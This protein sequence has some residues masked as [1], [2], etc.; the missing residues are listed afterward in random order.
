MTTES[1][2]ILGIILEFFLGVYTVFKL[3]NIDFAHS[4]WTTKLVLT[5]TGILGL[6][7]I[8]LICLIDL[9]VRLDRVLIRPKAI[10]KI[11]RLVGEDKVS[12]WNGMNWGGEYMFKLNDEFVKAEQN[13]LIQV[14]FGEYIS[15]Y[16]DWGGGFSHAKDDIIKVWVD[17]DLIVKDKLF[18]DPFYNGPGI[19]KCLKWRLERQYNK[20]KIGERLPVTNRKL[21]A[22]IDGMFMLPLEKRYEYCHR[23]DN[24]LTSDWDRFVNKICLKEGEAV[25]NSPNG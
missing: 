12:M 19:K 4:H 11:I 13:P 7:V 23:W 14:G 16:G 6:P 5:T 24:L 18:N 1:Y 2:W 22:A 15:G 8:I 9:V 21:R 3:A 10:D 20:I 17:N 25:C